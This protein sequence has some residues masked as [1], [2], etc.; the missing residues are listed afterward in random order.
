VQRISGFWA[1]TF[2]WKLK[3]LIVSLGSSLQYIFAL[4]N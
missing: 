1:E 3:W 2:A 4:I